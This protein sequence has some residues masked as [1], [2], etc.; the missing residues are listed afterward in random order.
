MVLRRRVGDEDALWFPVLRNVEVA[1][2]VAE[3]QAQSC[4]REVGVEA[5]TAVELE[6]FLL[7]TARM[8]DLIYVEE[9]PH[10]VCTSLGAVASLDILREL[11]DRTG[12]LRYEHALECGVRVG[13]FPSETLS[14]ALSEIRGWCRNPEIRGFD[15]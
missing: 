5:T 6:R 9:G 11:A 4:G 7:D 10:F 12:D 15:F 13:H 1:R 14:D 8:V 2:R 3:V